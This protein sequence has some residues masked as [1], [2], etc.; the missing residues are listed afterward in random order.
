[1]NPDLLHAIVTLLGTGLGA[2]FGFR[3]SLNGMRDNVK[4]VKMM[5]AEIRDTALATREDLRHLPGEVAE[6]VRTS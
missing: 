2:F 1:M 3:G 5:V 6:K 4:E